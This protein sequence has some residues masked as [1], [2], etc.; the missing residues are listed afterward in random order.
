MNVSL[1][2]ELEAWI[3]ERVE[4]GRYASASEVVRESLRLKQEMDQVAA[5]RL[6]ALRRDL[7]RGLGELDEGARIPGEEAVSRVL[8]G[9]R[10]D[11][12][13]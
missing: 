11:E 1:T 9:L 10:E 5:A 7:D 8:A 13:S 3:K 12:D 6:Q 2:P 4:S